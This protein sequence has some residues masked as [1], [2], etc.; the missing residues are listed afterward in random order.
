MNKAVRARLRA[1]GAALLL[2]AAAIGAVPELRTVTPAA[3]VRPS[4][5]RRERFDPVEQIDGFVLTAP[6]VIGTR[7]GSSARTHVAHPN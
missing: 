6:L 7:S 2:G 3:I 5:V 1:Y 4:A